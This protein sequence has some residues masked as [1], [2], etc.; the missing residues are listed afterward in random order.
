[1]KDNPQIIEKPYISAVI[2]ELNPLHH[3]H[4]LLLKT[5]AA[6]GP[7]VC[8]MSGN[9][10]QRGEPAIIDKWSR[11]KLALSAGAN[12]VLELPLPFAVSGAEAFASA[13]VRLVSALGLPGCLLFGSEAGRIAPLTAVVNALLSD[14]FPPLLKQA[15]ETP[16]RSFAAARQHAIERLLGRSF[17]EMMHSPNNILAIEYMKA[18]RLQG[19]PLSPVTIKRVGAAHDKA[20]VQDEYRSAGEIRASILKGTYREGMLPDETR[21]MLRQLL[22]SGKAPVS[23]HAME[24]AILYHLR[25]MSKAAYQQLPA[26]SE[27]LENRLYRASRTAGS[28]DELLALSKSKRYPEARLRRL[29]LNAFLGLRNPLPEGPSY[30]RILGMDQTGE[31]LLGAGKKTLPLLSKASTVNRLSNNA[32]KLFA[33]E[34]H[35]DDIYALF[36]PSPQP[37]GMDYTEPIIFLR[38]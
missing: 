21:D 8:V 37:C 4:A 3:G 24:H 19:C 7:V 6:I 2:C 16:N 32:Q 25:G 28:L 14:A 27:G 17:A 10:V 5:A 18:I 29:I 13:G 26:I 23:L 15:L 33:L 12:L 11:T 1:M 9:F 30:I 36:M 31:K 34:T 38:R 22:S 35:A 20:A